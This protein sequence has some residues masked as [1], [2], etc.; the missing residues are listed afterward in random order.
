MPW[1][2][3]FY[4]GPGG[5]ARP[6]EVA[7]RRMFLGQFQQLVRSLEGRTLE[8]EAEKLPFRF[9]VTSG[10]LEYTP[11]STGRVRRETWEHVSAALDRY[12]DTGSF[13]PGDYTD[14]TRNASYLLVVLRTLLDGDR[15]R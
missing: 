11:S 15:P 9:H 14:V 12:N 7:L 13:K 1:S 8:T 2:R 3:Q 4:G 6:A 5:L 10:G